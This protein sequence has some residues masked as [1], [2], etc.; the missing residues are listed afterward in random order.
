MVLFWGMNWSIMKIGLLSVPPVIFVLHRFAV[1]AIALLPFFIMLRSKMPRDRHTLIRLLVLCLIFVCIIIAQAIGLSQES[2]GIGAVLTYTQPLFVFCFAVLFLSEKATATR[3]LGV[4]VGFTGVILLFINK[5]GSFTFDSALVML[6]GAVLWAF[7]AVY[8]KKFLSH[9]DPLITHFSQLSVG[10]IPLIFLGL[11]TSNFVFPLDTSYVALL[12]ISS[13]G[14]LAV[15]N[16]IWLFLLKEEEATIVT[17]SSLI[18][19]VIALFFGW[20]LLGENFGVES[21]LGSALTLAGVCLINV[22]RKA[23]ISEEHP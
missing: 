16:V 1:S 17:G 23:K 5:T 10:V 21:L 9:V 11:T 19:P 12:M 14:A 2:S 4:T 18:V 22:K 20:Q 6:F 15:G 13:V 3:L 7:A 8:Y